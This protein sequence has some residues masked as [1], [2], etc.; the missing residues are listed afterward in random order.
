M[1]DNIQLGQK[2]QDRISGFSGI[3]NTVGDH[4]AGCRR[5]GVRPSQSGDNLEETIQRGD[6]EFFFEE[7]L[8]VLEVE[9][10]FT[11]V[12]EDSVT[13]VD[14]ELGEWAQDKVSK[15]QGSICVINCHLYNC[16]QIMLRSNGP[17]PETLWIDEPQVEVL[18]EGVSDE[19]GEHD[20]KSFAETGPAQDAPS[21]NLSSSL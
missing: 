15:F 16:P 21:E 4:I 8:N 14:F 9:N 20:D 10:Q 12:A 13:E 19:F 1:E 17:E 7:Q 3:V 18:D 6:E 11:D 5:I 2:V